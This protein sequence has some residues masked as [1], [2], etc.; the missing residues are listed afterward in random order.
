MGFRVCV[1][2]CVCVCVS[3]SDSQQDSLITE[4]SKHCIFL[5]QK[6]DTQDSER[7]FKKEIQNDDAHLLGPHIKKRTVSEKTTTTMTEIRSLLSMR[8]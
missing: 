3:C 8:T 7:Y 1:C 6:L 5:I 2:V 4:E